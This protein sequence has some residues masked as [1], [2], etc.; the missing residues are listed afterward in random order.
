MAVVVQSF[1]SISLDHNFWWWDRRDLDG[2]LRIKKSEKYESASSL[3]ALK[4]TSVGLKHCGLDFGF[5]SL[6]GQRMRVNKHLSGLSTTSPLPK[7]TTSLL[8]H[9]QVML[10]LLKN[11]KMSCGPSLKLFF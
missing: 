1:F 9:V 6:T 11:T 10:C 4:Q 2:N 8:S 3:N 5:S 7:A